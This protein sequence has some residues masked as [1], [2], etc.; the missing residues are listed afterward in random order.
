M[1]KSCEL[2]MLEDT[3][4]WINMRTKHCEIMCRHKDND[5]RLTKEHT[6][7]LYIW[8][9]GLIGIFILGLYSQLRFFEKHITIRLLFRAQANWKVSVAVDWSRSILRTHVTI[10]KQVY[11]NYNPSDG[12]LMIEDQN[13]HTRTSITSKSN[14]SIF[15]TLVVPNRD[16]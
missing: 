10:S 8:F 3:I 7:R 5:G 6:K 12:E 16:L 14:A 11:Q 13:S 15:I 9:L 2:Y 4:L 1:R